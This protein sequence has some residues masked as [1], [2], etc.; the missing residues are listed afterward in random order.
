[1]N[2][3]SN[4]RYI[5]LLACLLC[6]PCLAQA[7]D[8]H[9]RLFLKDGS[10]QIVTKYE[11]KG[12][13]VRYFSSE[14]DE[15]EELPNSIVDWPAT[16]Q[17]EKDQSAAAAAPEAVQFDKEIDADREA[18][19]AKLPSVAPGL[20]LPDEPGV[21]L[22]DNFQGEPQLVEL[23]QTA[24]DV[25][26]DKKANIFR[27]AIPGAGVKQTIEIEGAHAPV[28]S[29][30]DV[31]SIYMNVDQ[32]IPEADQPGLVP[33]S[34]RPGSKQQ[35]AQPQQ[36]EQ[37]QQPLVPFD[38]YRIVRA[39]VK[40]NKRIVG[41]VKRQ[42]TGKIS[43]EQHTVRTTITGITG[44]WLKLTPTETLAPG[45][46]AVIEVV[47]KQMNLYVWDFGVNPKAPA[48]ANPYKPEKSEPKPDAK[49]ES[50]PDTKPT[51]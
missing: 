42:V 30:V 13:R 18:A 51:P 15:W 19:A 46:Y 27:S 36:P 48:N 11:V 4:P 10:Y 43:E 5:W 35:P 24:G 39:E 12:D 41:D 34:T 22:F 2:H 44:G 32:A 28:Q 45:E 6:V 29:H 37:P 21:F 26:Q 7:P 31:P 17:Y 23:K 47:D 33:D 8:T 25:N 9:H 14:R 50:K 3:L 1:M 38:R 16:E 20:H 40:G 49:P